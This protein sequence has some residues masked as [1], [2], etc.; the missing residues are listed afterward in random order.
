MKYGRM[1]SRSITFI[2]PFTNLNTQR[3]IST[4]SQS[5]HWKTDLLR[6]LRGGHKSDDVLEGK[7]A[8]KH[9]L[10]HL[11]EIIV[12]LCKDLQD[13]WR[14]GRQ[15]MRLTKYFAV[16]ILLMEVREGGEY[17]TEGRHHDEEAG[18]NG[19]HLTKVESISLISV[20][21]V[22]RVNMFGFLVCQCQ[23]MLHNK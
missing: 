21:F 10:G 7:P 8:D 22:L 2:T 5:D 1:P 13:N 19:D 17:Q 18:D 9:G 12:L 6:L 23:P 3:I 16:L 15:E 20:V 4:L 11:E 14:P